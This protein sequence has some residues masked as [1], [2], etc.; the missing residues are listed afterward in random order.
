MSLG[1]YNGDAVV[2]ERP[3]LEL[4]QRW[5]LSLA[6]LLFFTILLSNQDIGNV[7]AWRTCSRTTYTDYIPKCN[8]ED[9]CFHLTSESVDDICNHRGTEL[10]IRLQFCTSIP[11]S[12]LFVNASENCTS[13]QHNK[14]CRTSLRTLQETDS[15]AEQLFG[16]FSDI[17]GRYD[18]IDGFSTM[19]RCSDCLTAYKEW[20][21]AT[22]FSF[23]ESGKAVK[24]CINTCHRVAARCPYLLPNI[25]YT[26]LPV[27][28]CPDFAGYQNVQFY[29][30]ASD[31]FDCVPH[32]IGNKNSTET[33]TCTFQMVTTNSSSSSSA[34]IHRHSYHHPALLCI[35][36][37]VLYD[38]INGYT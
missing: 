4:L 19:Y 20:I 16:D 29:G 26:G 24:P 32:P 10:D 9:Q 17:L 14:E 13:L 11:F 36:W 1:W 23:Y 3:Y 25:T 38:L 15:K 12:N 6:S 30:K 34:S 7:F 21:C 31:C 33:E 35:F 8:I 5:R 37:I 2:A 27:F 28:L 22:E 18:C